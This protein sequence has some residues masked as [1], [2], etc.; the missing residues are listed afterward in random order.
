ML[1]QPTSSPMMTRMFGFFAGVC[2]VAVPPPK[3]IGN[4]SAVVMRSFLNMTLPHKS[5]K[6]CWVAHTF[7]LRNRTDAGQ[8]WCNG[9]VMLNDIISLSG[10]RADGTLFF[11]VFSHVAK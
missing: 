7:Y 2:A 8:I 10:R 6:L 9:N 5:L 11:G 3:A 1:N 4:A